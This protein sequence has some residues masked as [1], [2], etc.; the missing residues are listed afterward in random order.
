[1]YNVG[2]GDGGF[3]GIFENCAVGGGDGVEKDVQYFVGSRAIAGH[4]WD[5]SVCAGWCCW[6]WKRCYRSCR[7]CGWKWWKGK[8]MRSGGEERRFLCRELEYLDKKSLTVR[9]AANRKQLAEHPWTEGNSSNGG[10]FSRSEPR[11]WSTL[12][13]LNR[14]PGSCRKRSM[15]FS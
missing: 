8:E 6:R 2:G 1:L 12:A 13:D 5:N 15:G 7:S 3:G 11:F 14:D 10:N 9:Y 4:N